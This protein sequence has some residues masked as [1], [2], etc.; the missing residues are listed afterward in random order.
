MGL[1]ALVF[2]LALEMTAAQHAF[3]ELDAMCARDGGRMWGRSLCGPIVFVEPAT[4]AYV[5][6]SATGKI[7]TGALP[8][9]IGIANTSVDW[10]GERWT[11]VM[12]PLPENTIARRALLAHESFHRIHPATVEKP[13]AHLD[14]LEGRWLMQL[15]WRALARALSGDKSAIRD[16]AAF[17]ARRYELFPGA[18]EEEKALESNEGLAEYTGIA[19]AV[20]VVSERAPYLVKQLHNAESKPTFVR[21][22]AYVTTPAWRTLG[23]KWSAGNPAG[24]EEAAKRYDGEKLLAAERLRDEKKKAQLAQFKTR[25]IDGL[26]VTIALKHAQMEFNPNEA[27]PFPP[28]GTVYPTLTLRDDWGSLVVRNGGALIASD[29]STVTVPEGSSGYTLTRK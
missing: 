11:M 27:I 9:S 21:S 15:E 13:N 20:P 8:E 22:F 23:A 18:A 14:T 24:V 5:S 3:E 16:A 17:R 2:T 25:F 12:W 1:F 10:N 4:R 29:W 19:M 28:H 7:E 6:R 26:H